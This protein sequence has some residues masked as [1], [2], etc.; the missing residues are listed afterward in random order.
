VTGSGAADMEEA[1]YNGVPYYNKVWTPV[2]SKVKEQLT[3]AHVVKNNIQSVP[4]KN[5]KNLLEK[6]AEMS[7]QFAF[8]NDT[9]LHVR[10]TSIVNKIH[11]FVLFDFSHP[12]DKIPYLNKKYLKQCTKID[13]ENIFY[14]ILHNL[15]SGYDPL[16]IPCV[17]TTG[18]LGL[19]TL[20]HNHVC[21][22]CNLFIPFSITDHIPLIPMC[23]CNLI[24]YGE[25]MCDA[26]KYR[27]FC[28]KFLSCVN[29]P[30]SCS[31]SSNYAAN[32]CTQCRMLD[33]GMIENVD[34][35][36]V[37]LTTSLY[38]QTLPIILRA[39]ILDLCGN[40]RWKENCSVQ[41][42]V[43]R[44]L[45]SLNDKFCSS[46]WLPPHFTF[47]YVYNLHSYFI[48]DCIRP[49]PILR[50]LISF[51]RIFGNIVPPFIVENVLN[52]V[53]I[54]EIV[55]ERMCVE[56]TSKENNLPL[57]GGNIVAVSQK[58]LFV[59]QKIEWN[60]FEEESLEL[61]E[62]IDEVQTPHAIQFQ[63]CFESGLD[64]GCPECGVSVSAPSEM[65]KHE[66]GK[67]HLRSVH[68]VE[69]EYSC[70][71]C[72][73]S[74]NS[75]TSFDEHLQ[76][77]A[78]LIHC[79][80]N[81]K[82]ESG[83]DSTVVEEVANIPA[84]VEVLSYVR[85][86]LDSFILKMVYPITS[87][88][89]LTDINVQ[90]WRDLTVDLA[91]Y[92]FGHLSGKAFILKIALYYLSLSRDLPPLLA[93]FQSCLFAIILY[94]LK[95]L[96]R[97]SFTR[98]IYNVGCK[99]GKMT[100]QA[101]EEFDHKTETDTVFKEIWNFLK[102]LL[103]SAHIDRISF[104]EK[105]RWFASANAG[106]S[107][108]E[109]IAKFFNVFIR[110][111]LEP[112]VAWVMKKSDARNAIV[113][114][115]QRVDKFMFEY[116]VETHFSTVNMKLLAS[117]QARREFFELVREGQKF[118]MYVLKQ[119]GLLARA[120]GM[121]V[122]NYNRRLEL[123]RVANGN[124]FSQQ[125]NKEPP[126]IIYLFGA[127]GVGK[128]Q[129]IDFLMTDLFF[130][131]DKEEYDS[132][133]HRF[134]R[135]PTTEYWDSYIQQEVYVIDDFLQS[136]DEDIARAEVMDVIRIAE[137]TPF[138]LNMA[139]C[140]SKGMNFFNSPFTILTSNINP[141]NKAPWLNQLI[142][143]PLAF[144][145]RLD[146]QAEVFCDRSKILPGMGFVRD[147]I[148]FRYKKGLMTWEQMLELCYGKIE[149]RT[150]R[151]NAISTTGKPVSLSILK[152][153]LRG[154]KM[155]T[156]SSPP[157]PIFQMSWKNC[158][159]HYVTGV[160]MA[161]KNT[162]IGHVTTKIAQ[163]WMYS[164]T[165][166]TELLHLSDFTKACLATGAASALGLLAYKYYNS[167]VKPSIKELAWESGGGNESGGYSDKTVRT[168]HIRN[169]ANRQVRQ[170]RMK[171]QAGPD[172]YDML[173]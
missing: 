53:D 95:C 38:F 2:M 132:T 70:V 123:A 63:M 14:S 81:M 148:T 9:K 42:A 18:E 12:Y 22:H 44:S 52:F 1:E 154:I 60:V 133:I 100:F 85:S 144:F 50:S 125:Q 159:S 115:M 105:G 27:S 34:I 10:D 149:K 163:G 164:C 119:E 160:R 155:Q 121:T 83:D 97:I 142:M 24:K 151:A 64:V 51:A 71:S 20:V 46:I 37:P 80:E 88:C 131:L 87:M 73:V 156:E 116:Q 166:S 150:L 120:W 126:L 136:R 94:I 138:P 89:G 69:S 137:N 109:K 79:A 117:F 75:K 23:M 61:F 25:F 8:S 21:P 56:N 54:H 59:L 33:V 93:S 31:I 171:E 127:P 66:K 152:E 168:N 67:K 28:A 165:P 153:R 96:S 7:S 130:L 108:F 13:R 36:F 15:S 4:T 112:I 6:Y 101:A 91:L 134:T 110:P 17:T 172:A 106:L 103:P 19:V 107:F 147:A 122:S 114:W 158:L 167:T 74:C 84:F 113:N 47:S 35:P 146:I 58:E 170:R 77:I 161:I 143:E 141:V 68:F 78:H 43:K 128:S 11:Q 82:F 118:G 65:E 169:A 104:L 41:Y 99:V 157:A 39:Y 5:N 3:F 32:L 49:L 62:D 90:M 124:V 98:A 139:A 145:R 140:D 92:T 26:S 173:Q 102:A 76:S 129:T 16:K 29:K 30:C 86:F 45:C 57:N 72:K 111:Y 48:T 55:L 40:F 135:N 162:M